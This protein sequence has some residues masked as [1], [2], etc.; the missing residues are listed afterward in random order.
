MKKT[1]MMVVCVA[2]FAAVLVGC[3]EKDGAAVADRPKSVFDAMT[4]EDRA[5]YAKS[6]I[7]DAWHRAVRTMLARKP[8]QYTLRRARSW[9]WC[10]ACHVQ[11]AQEV[12]AE[13]GIF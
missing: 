3:G 11:R 9:G 2:A 7:H 4:D 12:Q 13:R 10:A 1:L 8:V 5:F 6:F